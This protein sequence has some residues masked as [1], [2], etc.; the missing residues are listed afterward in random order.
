[1]TVTIHTKKQN[2]PEIN[3]DLLEITIRKALESQDKIIADVTLI[4]TDD[5]EIRHLNHVYRDV[6][7]TTDVLAFN[8][9][10][11]DPETGQYYLGDIVI[12]VD[13]AQRQALEN[14]HL[15]LDELMLL[16]IHGTLH[17]LGFD[18]ASA[19]QKDAMWKVQESILKNMKRN[20]QEDQK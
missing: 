17:L 2:A 11:I 4:L 3:R 19:Q 20:I 9:D 10:F 14:N 12:S 13:S 16:A 18:H 5:I 8:Q 1:M 7:Q 6:D 15:L